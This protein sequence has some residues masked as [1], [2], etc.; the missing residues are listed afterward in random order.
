[1]P[2]QYSSEIIND[3]W[4]ADKYRAFLN[5]KLISIGYRQEAAAGNEAVFS[6]DAPQSGPPKDRAYLKYLVEQPNSTTIKVQLWQGDG[7]NGLTLFP[8]TIGIATD[9]NFNNAINVTYGANENFQLRWVTFKSDEI[10]LVGAV[11]SDN[12]AGLMTAGFIFP[13][14]KPAWWGSTSLYAFAPSNSESGRFRILPGNPLSP[15]HHE[16][17]FNPEHFP[18][19]PNPGG[20]RD[21]LRRLVFCSTLGNAICGMTSSD[22]GII[23]CSGLPHFFQHE[24]SGQTW[25]SIRGGNWSPAVRIA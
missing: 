21:L 24:I 4:N 18:S 14:V 10:A 7:S 6:I 3:T 23:A 15:N 8:N 17:A 19:S 25:I 22:G 11:R 9:A 13:S 12:N 1:M 16:I 20:T 2:A 5:S